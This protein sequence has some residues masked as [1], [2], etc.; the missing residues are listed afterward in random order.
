[1]KSIWDKI[2]AS[3]LPD[4]KNYLDITWDD[5]AVDSKIWNIAVGGMTYLDGKIGAAQDYTQPGLHRDLLMD[6]VRYARDGAADI[7]ENNY[8]HLIL[9]AQNERRVNAYAAENANAP[10][11]RNQP[12]F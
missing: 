7:F 4:I 2:R 11:E 6:Y 12:E 10:D 5:D 1:M 9:A 8:R 3:L